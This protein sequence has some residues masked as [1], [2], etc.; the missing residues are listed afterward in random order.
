LTETVTGNALA[1]LYAADR[2]HDL[3]S[4]IRPHTDLKRA[5][6][7]QQQ[8][9]CERQKLLQVHQAGA[10][11][12][13]LLTSEMKRFKRFFEPLLIGDD[14]SVE[15]AE[16]TE[17]FRLLLDIGETLTYQMSAGESRIDGAMIPAGC[18]VASAERSRPSSVF[19]ATYG[20][21]GRDLDMGTE[22]DENEHV[23]PDLSGGTWC[24]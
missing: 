19:M 15:R 17:P 21:T 5:L 16:L 14:G 10:I 20:A 13:D 11:P 9:R 23:P 3:V 12:A 1:S 4:E 8:V 6:A 7:R 18:D 24:E 2:Y 22:C